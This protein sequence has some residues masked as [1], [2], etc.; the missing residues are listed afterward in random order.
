MTT[1]AER[2]AHKK[3]GLR[4]SDF[5]CPPTPTYP[6]WP[7]AEWMEAYEKWFSAYTRALNRQST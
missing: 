7:D 5:P 1:A 3:A 4:A 6:Y 2:Q